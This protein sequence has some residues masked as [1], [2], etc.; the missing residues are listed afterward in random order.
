M[1]IWPRGGGRLAKVVLA[2]AGSLTLGL[3]L[4]PGRE[5][6][7]HAAIPRPIPA[8]VTVDPSSP[9]PVVPR[10]FLGLSTEYW[11]LPIFARHPVL[12]DR[13]LSVIRVSDGGPLTVR[14]GGDSADVSLWDP[15]SIVVPPWLFAVTPRWVQEASR[16]VR[17]V[18]A[19]LILDLNL[20]IDSPSAAATWVQAVKSGLPAHSIAG[21]EIGNEPD[22][23]THHFLLGALMPTDAQTDLPPLGVTPRWYVSA[24]VSYARALARVAP[25]VPLLGPVVGNPRD[26]GW[27]AELVH[28]AGRVLG[29]VSAH[30]YPLS[31]CV[32]RS[33][34]WFATVARVLSERTSAG[35]ARE[36]SAAVRL[37]RRAGVPFRL[38]ELN[39]VTCGGRP[40]VSD[41]FATAL[42]APDT[43]FELLRAGVASADI[44]LR[45]DNNNAPFAIRGNRLVARPLLYGLALFARALG[46]GA[47]L[48]PGSLHAPDSLHLKAW[49]VRLKGRVLHVLVVNKGGRS[50][51]V[52][53][54]L[55]ATRPASVERLLAPSARAS[56]GVTLDGQRLDDRG[57]W[58][59]RRKVETLTPRAGRYRLLVPG[60]SAA[61]V[62]VPLASSSP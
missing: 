30:V 62:S 39:S 53:F 33:S 18:D 2:A 43:L 32:R 19:R 58:S 7:S 4:T 1:R 42:W 40:G 10:S 54:N 25:G 16:L 8:E 57:I 34:R 5:E 9:G 46:P 38:T 47:R 12:V 37:A 50:A 15:G 28:G 13:A 60:M 26:V 17:D 49:A 61:L 59:G 55:P 21:F 3:L 22:L 6:L 36:V 44:H 52:D 31:G 35:V 56:S 23:H 27:I 45:A 29:A 24:F 51:L 14:I 48:V 41:T 11:V 20:A